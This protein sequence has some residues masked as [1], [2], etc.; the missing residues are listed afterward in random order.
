MPARAVSFLAKLTFVAC[1]AVAL[2]PEQSSAGDLTGRVKVADGEALFGA[3]VVVIGTDH[4]SHTDEHGEFRFPDL[5]AG[6]YDVFVSHIGFK[7]RLV[8][9]VVIADGSEAT[10]EISVDSSPVELPQLVVSATRR[11]QSFAE[12]PISMSVAG[13]QELATHNSFRLSGALNYVSGVNLVGGQVSIRGSSGFSRGTGS[14]VLLLVD[15]TPLLSADNGDIKWDAIPTGEVERVEVIK[16]AGSALYG[17]GALGGVINVITRQPSETPQ[18]R[19]R[20]INGMYAQPAHGSWEWRDRPMYLTGVE[21]SHSRRFGQ[22]GVIVSAGHNR[23]TG[24]HEN[25]ESDRYHLYLKGVRRIGPRTSL[26][27]VASVAVDDHGVFVQWKDRATPLEVPDGDEDASTVSWKFNLRSELSHAHSQFL[28]LKAST[29]YYRTDFDNSSA[30][31]GLASVGHKIGSELQA[32]YTKWRKARATFG[33]SAIGDVVRSPGDFIG[34][35]TAVNGALYGQVIFEPGAA[36]QIAAGIRYD[37]HRRSSGG[38]SSAGGVCP[39]HA[40]GERTLEHQLSPQIG[41]SYTVREGT[42]MR[43]SFGRGFRAPSAIEV[44]GQASVSGL[45]LC[46]NPDLRSERS[47]SYEA[48]VKQWITPYMLIDGA[49]FWNTYGGLV[50]GRPDPEITDGVLRASFRNISRARVRGLEVE[51]RIA[52]PAGISLRTSYTYLDAVEFLDLDE[53]LPTYCH[54]ELNGATGDEVPLPYRPRHTVVSNLSAVR[55]ATRAGVGFQFA[56]RFDRVSGLFPECRRDHLPLYLVDLYASRSLGPVDLN[57]RI[58][59][60][61]QYHYVLTERKL[62]APRLLSLSISGGID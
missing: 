46:P 61:L 49:L 6:R 45:L 29:F 40:D 36:A 14:R 55:G 8:K 25:G 44:H 13:R 32:D 57:A 3:T 50:E 17:T 11:I 2:S 48:G 53:P 51:Q 62:R 15:G 30:A 37:V 21:M 4:A 12:A 16:G 43:A 28:G 9:G 35:R 38:G 27:S 23:S 5:P 58:D 7:S 42:V 59:N 18:T 47:W 20:L 33:V 26:T 22:S 60:L 10:V 24:Y 31:G 1:L 54:D 34:R 56:S 41:M 52:L 19:F 39:V